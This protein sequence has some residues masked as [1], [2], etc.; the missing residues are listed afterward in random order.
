MGTLKGNIYFV[1]NHY[2][3]KLIH[4]Q[5]ILQTDGGWDARRRFY[6]KNSG[7]FW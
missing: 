6:F 3:L 5:T 2:P 7:R 4:I 1:L